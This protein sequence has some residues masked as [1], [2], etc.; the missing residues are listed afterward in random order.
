ML[1]PAI[2]G[3]Q[4]N[5]GILALYST[6]RGG[7]ASIV[8]A[9]N[10]FIYT[11][12]GSSLVVYDT[13]EPIY[14]RQF[15]K[16]F[17]GPVTDLKIKDGFLYVA[18]GHE[19]LSKWDLANPMRPTIVGKYELNDFETA[20]W[21]ISFHNDSLLIAADNAVW[22]LEERS[23]LGPS[24]EKVGTFASQIA[25]TGH[26]IAGASV[27]NYYLAA[28]SGKQKGIG[29]GI[30]IFD[31]RTGERLNFFHYEGG[32][33]SGLCYE[34]GQNFAWLFGG[35]ALGPEAHCI[36]LS[37]EDVKH[38]E[39][40][41]CDT[42]TRNR[43]GVA[44]VG[45]GMLLENALW[46]PCIG[47]LLGSQSPYF[48]LERSKGLSENNVKTQLFTMPAAPTSLTSSSGQI[49]VACGAA[50]IHSY[51]KTSRVDGD[52]LGEIGQSRPNGGNCLG[53][54]AHEE[55]LLTA[56]SE[57]GFSL[58]LIQ[59]RK[60]IATK[61][62]ERFGT[63]RQIK[64]HSNGQTAIC[65]LPM[66]AGDS[67]ITV[68][69]DKGKVL[70]ELQ[71]PF[72]HQIVARWKDRIVCARDDL[73]GFDIVDCSK[74]TAPF[75]EKSVLLNLHS[76]SIDNVGRLYVTTEHNVRIFDLNNG[77]EEITT[78]AKYGE[79]FQ[80]ICAWDE[81]VYIATRKRGLIKA[82]L[83]KDGRK[84]VLSEEFAWK[85]PHRQ[86]EFMTVDAHGLYLGYENYGIY[87]LDKATFET[88]GHYRTGL[89]Y[90]GT[91][92]QNLT[93]L[94]TYRGKIFL[95]EYFGQVTVLQRSDLED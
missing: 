77:F 31:I 69:L 43:Y 38:P 67:I 71:G 11:A 41:A 21:E 12:E 62:F 89:H 57:A 44:G 26:I 51:S 81:H 1:W 23:G 49:H 14:R 61:V 58:H 94:F 32:I 9:Q 70:A 6:S 19:G 72:G 37:L 75:K 86:P 2:L 10:S 68:D 84:L 88:Q 56:N 53:A 27:G 87:A 13:R 55:M 52:S 3:A 65:W 85:M 82:K 45:K 33:P 22:I 5:P 4:T 46:L 42:I 73:K 30:H 34:A 76:L 64:I 63:V 74:P 15:E 93:G 36:A 25:Q 91:Q 35:P 59:N 80:A 48:L 60:T 29:Q 16:R 24:F 17:N 20:F 90:P 54:D 18:N 39:M 92:A 83:V 8:L 79:G 78:Y 7:G 40:L 28:I 95:S 47:S 50:G 66:V